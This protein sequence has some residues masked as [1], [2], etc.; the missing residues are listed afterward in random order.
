MWYYVENGQQQ[1][2]VDE[3]QLKAMASAE[4]ISPS[5]LVWK[6]GMAQW[7]PYSQAIQA[8]SVSEGKV[9]C[10]SCRNPFLPGE[11]VLI[12]GHQV[13]AVCK[14]AFVQKLLEGVAVGSPSLGTL[15]P[16]QILARPF[17][18]NISSSFSRALALLQKDPLMSIVPFLLMVCVVAVGY[19]VV[20]FAALLCFPLL[21]FIPF[22]VLGIIGPL[23]GG[24]YAYYLEKSRGGSPPLEWMVRGFKQRFFDLAMTGALASLIS[25]LITMIGYVPMIVITIMQASRDSEVPNE[26]EAIVVLIS[27]PLVYVLMFYSYAV[28][29]FAIP[30]VMDKGARIFQA[31]SLSFQ[32]AHKAIWRMM[33]LM[34]VLGLVYLGGFCALC[35]GLFIALPMMFYMMIYTY[36]D[37]FDDMAPIRASL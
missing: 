29:M 9:P 2:P 23:L 16:E 20:I 24:L 4:R 21:F 37:A 3:Q 19:I 33:L 35:V 13:C 1:G 36:R 27:L 15:S 26:P 11:L 5:T 22:L 28:T 7:Q 6:S 10:A 32:M 18:P 17:R 30:L 31:I 12:E 25:G 8:A 34:L 14:P